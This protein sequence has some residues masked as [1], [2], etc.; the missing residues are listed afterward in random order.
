[1]RKITISYYKPVLR[2]QRDLQNL[3]N[4]VGIEYHHVPYRLIIISCVII[5]KNRPLFKLPEY[6][7]L[8]FWNICNLLHHLFICFLS[9]YL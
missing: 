7:L 8:Y 9:T 6:I 3:F 1:M 2:L 5:F 4:R